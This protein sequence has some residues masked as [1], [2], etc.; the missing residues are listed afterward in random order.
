[1]IWEKI[2]E[3]NTVLKTE[4]HTNEFQ[5]FHPIVNFFYFFFVIIFSIFFMHPLCIVLSF[6]CGLFYIYMI[7][8]KKEIKRKLSYTIPLIIIMSVINPLFN[9]EGG[10]ILKYFKNGNPLTL[11]S[12]IYGIIASVMFCGVI[13]WFWCFNEVMTSDKFIYLF[14][15]IIPT[16]SLALSMTLR[17]VPLFSKETKKVINAQKCIGNDIHNGSFLKK[18]KNGLKILSIMITRSLENSIDTADSMKSRGYGL[19]KRTSFSNFR[20][21]KRDMITLVFLFLI[22][23]YIIFGK[24][25]GTMYIAYYPF[26]KAS[27]FSLFELSVFIA[28]FMLLILPVFIEISEVIKW[29]VIKSKI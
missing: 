6:V 2:S 20:F 8:G 28:Y 17:F 3:E 1:M 27:S 21:T 9:H 13:C 14:G 16:L 10:T 22:S 24:V 23:A 18:I 15:K 12:I 4:T 19:F 7:K 5:N 26:I 11:E 25:M 29:N